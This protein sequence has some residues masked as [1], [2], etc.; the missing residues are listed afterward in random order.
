MLPFEHEE[1]GAYDHQE[2]K[3]VIPAER[4][5]QVKYREDG[6]NEKGDR[7]LYDFQLRR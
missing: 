4:F 3:G 6:K 2:G 5:F 7:L 1:D